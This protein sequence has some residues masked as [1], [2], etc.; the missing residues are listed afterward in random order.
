MRDVAAH[1][2]TVLAHAVLVLPGAAAIVAIR[3]SRKT[4]N[5]VHTSV[6]T[7]RTSACATWA[8]RRSCR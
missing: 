1:G 7:A 8:S 6:N 4:A 3:V 5:G 2:K